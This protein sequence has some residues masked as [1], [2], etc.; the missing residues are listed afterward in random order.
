M[1]NENFFRRIIMSENKLLNYVL[2]QYYNKFERYKKNWINRGW[3]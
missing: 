2:E 1:K 3:L